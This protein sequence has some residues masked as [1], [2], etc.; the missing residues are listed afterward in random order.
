MNGSDEKVSEHEQEQFVASMYSCLPWELRHHINTFCVQNSYDD[1]VIVRRGRGD[2]PMLLVRQSVGTHSYHWTEDSTLQQLSPDRIGLQASREML[3]TYYGT[4]TF[5]F[6]QDE[7]ECVQSFLAT[8]AFGLT[9]R[10]ADHLRR[11]HLQVQPFA[12]ARLEDPEMKLNKKQTCCRALESLDA[13]RSP[14]TMIEVH[15]DL[16]EWSCDEDESDMML[17]DASSFMYL[18]IKTTEALQTSGVKIKLIL[19]GS[20]GE[21]NGVE[22]CSSSIPSLGECVT[23]MKTAYQ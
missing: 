5:K 8:D 9:L 1:E 7:L 11:L 12:Y 14:R 6:I 4:R 20:W 18:I 19:E 16:A 22:L 13:L 15:V 2:K 17:D 3:E 21:R 23:I 10:P